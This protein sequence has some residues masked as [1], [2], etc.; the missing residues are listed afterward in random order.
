MIDA[1]G[2]DVVV[3]VIHREVAGEH[4]GCFVPVLG[5]DSG[6]GRI[7][8]DV[9]LD[10]PVVADMKFVPIREFTRN[11][12]YGATA[13]GLV[14]WALGTTGY[15][16]FPSMRETVIRDFTGWH[17]HEGGFFGYPNN[18]VT[19]DGFIVR[20]HPRAF[21]RFEPGVAWSS[22]DY[23]AENVTIRR[24]NIQGMKTAICCSTNTVGVFRIE[25]SYFRTYDAA[26]GNETLETPGTGAGA[27]GRRTEI[28]NSRF[29]AWPGRPLQTVE[30]N[31]RTDRGNSHTTATDQVF[32]YGY[33]ETRAT[34]FGCSIESR[35]RKTSRAVMR[36]A[37]TS[38]ADPKSMASPVRSWRPVRPR[39][40]LRCWRRSSG[41]M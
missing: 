13:T 10:E 20:G 28:W 39:R 15:D 35:R 33:Q 24:A 14:T 27:P 18:R 31:W 21:G 5:D 22:G 16:H 9:T 11:E 19:F 38:R 23:W 36:P 1:V 2:G 32:V 25:D 30:M 4:V 34:T 29:E 12:A 6:T 8:Y 40:P 3:H 37:M 26:F 41:I 17:L 7:E